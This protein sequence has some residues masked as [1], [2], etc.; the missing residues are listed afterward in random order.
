MRAVHRDLAA[1]VAHERAQTVLVRKARGRVAEQRDEQDL[2]PRIMTNH[3]PEIEQPPT[4]LTSR[5]PRGQSVAAAMWC[6]F[7]PRT[8]ARFGAY[9][10]R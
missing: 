2:L 1:V 8:V 5:A 7:I 4:P 3:P 10:T 9:Y 6:T